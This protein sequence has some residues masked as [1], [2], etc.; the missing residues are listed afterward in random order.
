MTIDIDFL[1]AIKRGDLVKIKSYLNNNIDINMI[2]NNGN[3][4]LINAI[5][6]NH[7]NTAKL[8]IKSGADVNI[9]NKNKETALMMFKLNPS[10]SNNIDSIIDMMNFLIK[11]NV[12]INDSDTNGKTILMKFVN[13][14]YRLTKFLID[15]DANINDK[16]KDG[17]TALVYAI[18]NFNPFIQG[19][20]NEMLIYIELLVE[21]GA[22]VNIKTNTGETP[23]IVAS[24]KHSDEIVDFLIKKGANVNE[25]D[26]K[27]ETAL[28]KVF[29]YT[30]LN[31]IQGTVNGDI[32][33]TLDILLKAKANIHIKNNQGNSVFSLA[34]ERNLS[35][36][37]KLLLDNGVD[38]AKED[39]DIN[40]LFLKSLFHNDNFELA[41]Y[42]LANGVDIDHKDKDENTFL[43]LAIEE[44]YSMGYI[45]VVE[46]LIGNGVDIDAI[47]TEKETAL[48][49]AMNRNN[50]AI[51]ELLDLNNAKL[52]MDRK[53]LVKNID[54][55][56]NEDFKKIYPLLIKN[57]QNS[58]D[59]LEI[60]L[61]LES[62]SLSVEKIE[63]CM[64]LLR[65]GKV[66]VHINEKKQTDNTWGLNV[67]QHNL[68]D[69]IPLSRNLENNLYY[70]IEKDLRESLNSD[71]KK[72][73]KKILGDYIDLTDDQKH[74]PE[75]LSKVLQ[76]FSSDEKLKYSNH[77]WD[78]ELN[79]GVYIENLKQGFERVAENLK[80]LSPELYKE[81][82]NF[83]F[84]KDEKNI[85][86]SSKTIEDKINEDISPY[87]NDIQLDTTKQPFK[88][89]AEAIDNFKSLFVVKQDDKKLKLFKRITPIRTELKKAPDFKI[90]IN[91]DNLKE[92]KISKFFT[93]TKR[94]IQA[95]RVILLDI[96]EHVQDDTE[97]V[98]IEANEI[99]LKEIDMV[100][101]KIIHIN[102]KASQ[103]SETLKE[104]INKNGGN[105]QTIYNN[106]ISVCDWSIDTECSN[107]RYKIDYLYP[108]IDNNKPHCTK[109]E[110]T[111]RGFT[112]ILR[113]YK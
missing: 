49:I 80:I 7:F 111:I 72:T 91:L 105:F 12:N 38:I 36:P 57:N 4:A 13:V 2:D 102:S 71:D 62:S 63:M 17:K 68:K 64:Y 20:S 45:E 29:K 99:I 19:N 109:I 93:D 81:M 55:F 43:L 47:N 3:T 100:E 77:T 14:N 90:D 113:F 50:I 53:Y 25:K 73:F 40:A 18:N 48:R 83:L 27:G 37:I 106:L 5:S 42:L 101:I 15:K 26:K 84:S 28:L 16:D 66:K 41:N 24:E 74:N 32:P 69:S 31:S 98:I 95:I 30:G 34:V 23:L 82:N 112:H 61:N 39:I 52:D 97:V 51:I 110:D 10:G 11:Y 1:D 9:S 8:L 96:N 6:N 103:T 107:G 33:K 86:W 79:Y 59:D 21:N 44:L 56:Q 35:I 46:Y 89:F 58:I 67:K 92:T 70:E 87:P 88:T 65:E 78:T 76:K 85:G 60:W 22:E 104:T 75:T 94:L 54:R 108:Q